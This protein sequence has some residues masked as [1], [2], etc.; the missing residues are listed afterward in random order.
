MGNAVSGSTGATIVCP[1]PFVS[2]D[3]LS[4]V[5]PCPSDK[6]FVRKGD[7]NGYK[8]V[9]QSDESQ[10]VPLVT[11][12]AAFT[13]SSTLDQLQQTNPSKAA[14]FTSERDR[15]DREFAVVWA[16]IDKQQKI[17][18]AFKA[19]Q[20][21]ENARDQSPEA[22]QIARTTYYTLLKGDTWLDEERQRVS[23]AEVEPEIQRYKDAVASIQAR[24][25]EQQKTIDVVQGVKDKVL[26]LRDDFKYSV[27]TFSDQLEK[28]R[29]QINLENRSREKE[30]DTTW[31]WV[32]LVLNVILVILLLYAAYVLVRKV[33]FRPVV[34]PTYTIGAPI[35]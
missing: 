26:S 25:Q 34:T 28:L 27:N 14:E 16:N 22:Y 11:I 8:C 31:A 17:D 5:M 29:M 35:R 6:R 15:F 32:N 3:A 7:S 10:F 13:T 9:Y 1:A 33:F 23:K 4:C 18:D 24:T 2:A 30:T 21:A 12:G 20:A 19:L